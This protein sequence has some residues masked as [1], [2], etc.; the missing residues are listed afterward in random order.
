MQYELQKLERMSL[1]DVRAIAVSMGLNPRRSQSIRGMH[2]LITVP[3]LFRPK[4][5]HVQLPDCPL[6]EN[7]LAV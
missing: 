7:A 5:K 3:R 4:K 2:R 6:S 1:E